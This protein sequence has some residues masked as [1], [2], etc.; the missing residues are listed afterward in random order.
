MSAMVKEKTIGRRSFRELILIL[1]VFNL[2]FPDSV[3][4]LRA[5][6]HQIGAPR[7]A[8]LRLIRGAL[9]APANL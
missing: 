4:F 7:Q 3:N 8:Q 1:L 6:F 2:S 9:F 5:I